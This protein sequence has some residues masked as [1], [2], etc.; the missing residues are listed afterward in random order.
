[1]IKG[2]A[3]IRVSEA[4]A[5]GLSGPVS[6]I[7]PLLIYSSVH[8]PETGCKGNPKFQMSHLGAIAENLGRL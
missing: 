6:P 1:M 3:T 8:N 5:T 2:E 4:H 7:K